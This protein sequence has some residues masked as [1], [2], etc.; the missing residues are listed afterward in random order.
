MKNEKYLSR[1]FLLASVF[2]CCQAISF[3]QVQF[4][5]DDFEDL[6]SPSSGTRT[7]SSTVVCG[8]PPATAYFEHLTPSDIS[9]GTVFTGY[10][11]SKFW[12][13][14]DIDKGPMC[15]NNSVTAHQDITWTGI[16]IAGKTDLS[17]KGLFAVGT[18]TAFDGFGMLNSGGTSVYDY[19]IIQY[20]ID[21]GAWTDLIRFFPSVDMGGGTLAIETSGDSLAA[22]EGPGLTAVATEYSGN[23][24]GTGTTLELKMKVWS[25]SAAEEILLDHFRLFESGLSPEIQISGNGNN[26]PNG[27]SSISTNDFT[28]FGAQDRCSGSIVKTFSIQN[29]GMADLSIGT[30]SITGLNAADFSVTASPAST[31]VPSGFTSVE[32]TYDPVSAGVSSA[33]LIIPNSDGDESS[34]SFNIGG[35]AIDGTPTITSAIPAARCDA[36]TVD[37]SATASGGT[38]NWYDDPTAGNFIG[39]GTTLST[40]NISTSMTYYVDATFG[41]CTSARTPVTATVN[42]TPTADAPADVIACDSYVLPALNV[43]NYYSLTGGSGGMLN[44]GTTLLASTQLY[45]YAETGTT[46]NCTNENLF[47]IT[48]NDCAGLGEQDIEPIVLYPNPALDQLTIRNLD[49]QGNQEIRL[50]DLQGKTLARWKI[51]QSDV[52]VSVAEFACGSYLIRI[53]GANSETVLPIQI[54]H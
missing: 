21:G 9:S 12:A 53:S 24:V 34:F 41:S 17:F 16:N 14:E 37:L 18:P 6:D 54:L 7:P 25:N 2:F 11:G 22:G 1:F 13:I 8:G 20:R 47:M 27:S 38:L 40:P 35:T 33:T 4:W 50:E 43:G 19:L 23:I 15:I 10:S 46:P 26:I 51:D 48:I 36:G 5:S 42:I 3:A 45:V 31:V 29:T 39:S 32:I 44:V 30:P 49:P 28:D 52:D